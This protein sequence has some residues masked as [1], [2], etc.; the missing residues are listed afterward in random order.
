[1]KSFTK[2]LLFVITLS[3]LGAG[4]YSFYRR[5]KSE[6]RTAPEKAT[7]V[8]QPK[9]DLKDVQILD[10]LNREY[11]TLI[12]AVVPSVVSVN[13]SKRV[14]QPTFFM[15]QFGRIFPGNGGKSVTVPNS[16]GS[17]VI[18]SKEGHVITNNHVIAGDNGQHVDE[19]EVVLSDGRTLPATV[20]D[21]D[22][23]T[24]IAVLKV[25][26]DDLQPLPFGNS[27]EVLVGERVFAVGNPF[28]L[29]ESVSDGIISAKG[30]QSLSDNN[31]SEFLQT[32]AAI[33]PGNSGGP[34]INIRGEI[35]GINTMI[36]SQDGGF[37]GIGL[38][39][40]SNTARRVFE[41]I[42][43]RGRVLRGWLG[44]TGIP[45]NERI[46]QQMG[47]DKA[48]DGVLIAKV[49]PGS[50]ADRAKIQ[51]LDIIVKFGGKPTRSYA[52]LR[53]EV[54][55]RDVNEEVEIELLRN[56]EKM[57]V[58]ATIE[59]PAP[60]LSAQ[61]PMIPNLPVSPAN[62]VPPTR[63]PG[64][65]SVADGPVLGGVE[66]QELTP[67]TRQELQLPEQMDGVVVRSIQPGSNAA[68][69]LRVNDVIESINQ[70]QVRS[71]EDF[72]NAARNLDPS[73]E[74]EIQIRRERARSYVILQP[75]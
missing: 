6:H 54:L 41:S 69:K 53:R 12:K 5:S 30:R 35:I 51:E 2:F 3:L 50:P 36:A 16:L 29:A 55:R 70:Q 4:V 75:S 67:R 34:L 37:Q 11:T 9:I 8:E 23:F 14:T 33:N 48:P 21:S 24:D 38:A 64:S 22:P 31:I 26:G 17:G 66:V 56:G 52:D 49:E 25:E 62:P 63:R 10:A 1:M 15:D 72:M 74:H 13:T 58:K 7:L 27:E 43:S 44:V 71:V 19:I 59:E 18:V 45:W 32:N 73:R 20:I 57:I 42:I 47:L 65:S 28:G 40:P 60:A 39:V 68:K 46:L 61:S